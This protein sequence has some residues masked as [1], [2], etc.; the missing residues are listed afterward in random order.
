MRPLS[1]KRMT[2]RAA[3]L[4]ETT[5][6]I[7][8]LVSRKTLHRLISIPLSVVTVP[9]FVKICEKLFELYPRLFHRASGLPCRFISHELLRRENDHI[10]HLDD[11]Q[12]GLFAKAQFLPNRGWNRQMPSSPDFDSWH[13][14]SNL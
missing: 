7:K 13:N 12:C 9:L 6:A 14:G 8:A 2:S 1:P 10:A 11:T 3:P 4:G 5:P